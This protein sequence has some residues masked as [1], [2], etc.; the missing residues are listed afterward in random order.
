MLKDSSLWP[1][2]SYGCLA[3]WGDHLLE[4]R[5][6]WEQRTEGSAGNKTQETTDISILQQV[7]SLE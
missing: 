5:D 4:Q 6:L 3:L 2:S 1:D 7:T